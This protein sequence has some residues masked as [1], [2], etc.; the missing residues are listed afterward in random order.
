MSTEALFGLVAFRAYKP[1][2]REVVT[3]KHGFKSFLPFT[4]RTG[5]I[6]YHKEV[7]HDWVKYDFVKHYLLAAS[8][9]N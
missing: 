6:M 1:D 3:E 4:T 9:V 7:I 5:L 8:H 2:T